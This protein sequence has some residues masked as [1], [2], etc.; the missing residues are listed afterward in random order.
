MIL[1]AGRGV[2]SVIFNFAFLLL[3][4]KLLIVYY[5]KMSPESWRH[6]LLRVATLQ[7]FGW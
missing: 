4:R 5:Q 6:F 1:P 7:F 3:P 2:M